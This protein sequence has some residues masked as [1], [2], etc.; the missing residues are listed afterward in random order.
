MEL[1][2]LTKSTRGA[3]SREITFPAIGA[4]RTK[5]IQREKDEQ[6]NDLGKDAEGKLITR[7]ETV[8]EFYSDGVI[9]SI[10]EALSLVGGNL[11]TV[12]DHFAVG[13][14]KASYTIE[15]NK[16]ELDELL[17]GQNLDEDKLKAFKR[18]VRQVMAVTGK[19]AAG[20]VSLLIGE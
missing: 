10:D 19:D 18:A 20:A 6:G 14:N 1:I 17:A 4:Y 11:Q 9:T 3:N 13:F 2:N 8:Q 15:A 5:T 7:A 16:D 12:L